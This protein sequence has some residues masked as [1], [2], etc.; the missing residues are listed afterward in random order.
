MNS[1]DTEGTAGGKNPTFPTIYSRKQRQNSPV[2]LNLAL[3]FILLFL[4]LQRILHIWQTW[5]YVTKHLKECSE[6]FALCYSSAA[7]QERQKTTSAIPLFTTSLTKDHAQNILPFLRMQRWILQG[8][9]SATCLSA[10]S[11]TTGRALIQPL[12][13]N[14]ANKAQE[15]ACIK[16]ITVITSFMSISSWRI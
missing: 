13:T 15:R 3:H 5:S 2:V 11:V 10:P 12:Q 16:D 8:P 1:S 7:S 14:W 6:A 9:S 4:T